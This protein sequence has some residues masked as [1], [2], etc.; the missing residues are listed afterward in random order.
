MVRIL[1][2]ALYGPG[3]RFYDRFTYWFFAGEW[4]RWQITAL[5]AI[6]AG[7]VVV[8]LGAGTGALAAPVAER[9]AVWIG[10]ERSPHMIAVAKQRNR[11]PRPAFVRADAARLPLRT[12]LA[13]AIVTTFPSNYIADPL[14]LSETQRVLKQ[15]GRLVVVLTG[16]L[17]AV[18]IR[19]R[20]ARVAMT[21]AAGGRRQARPE[22]IAF[23]GFCGAWTW[24]RTAHGHALVFVGQARPTPDAGCTRPQG[25]AGERG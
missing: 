2:Q 11:P 8:E 4:R 23:A 24:H 18:G 22:P 12:Q 1:F 16:D 7:S 21:I 17:D 6:P 25:G 14:V 10:I 13:D 9:F 19:R 20:I 15:D 5:D 3:A